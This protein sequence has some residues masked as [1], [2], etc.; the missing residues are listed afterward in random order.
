MKLYSFQTEEE[1]A[2]ELTYDQNGLGF[3]AID[4]EFL[5]SLAKQYEDKGSLSP[6]QLTL[7]HEKLPKYAKQLSQFINED[8]LNEKLNELR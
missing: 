4:S 8:Y 2:D 7:I 3:G 1:Q 6:M 5:T